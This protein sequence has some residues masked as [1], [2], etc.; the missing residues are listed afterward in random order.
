[1]V[2][3]EAAVEPV[4]GTHAQPAVDCAEQHVA[5]DERSV[6]RQP[7][8]DL[9]RAGAR[10]EGDRSS[11]ELLP[12]A[13]HIGHPPGRIAELGSGGLR[14]PQPRPGVATDH[15]LGAPHV[16]MAR[17]QDVRGSDP[18][19]VA[20]EGAP[21]AL[22]LVR[23]VGKQRVDQQDRVAG[24]AVD[25]ADVSLPAVRPTARRLPLRMWRAPAPQTGRDL[26]H[27]HANE[28]ITRG[29]AR[30]ELPRGTVT[31]LFTDVEG[32][33][34][35][36][37]R[38]GPSDYARALDRHRGVLREAFAQAGGVEVDTQGDA[39][40]VAFAT[41]A[42]A[43]AAAAAV[44]TAL[45]SGPL[46]VRIGIHT[47]TPDLADDGYVGEDVHRGARIAA[48]AHGGQTL[49]SQA[50]AALLDGVDLLDLGLHRLKDFE[51]ST[52]IFQ[53]AR[54]TF[55]PLRTPGS[56]DLPTPATPFLGRQQ[57]LLD[58]ISVVLERD[59][60]LLT[61]VGPGG[62]GKTRFAIE[63][64]RL[65]ADEADGGTLFLPLAPLRDAGLV[66]PAL[67][68]R[69]GAPSP[70][71]Q[72]IAARIADRRVHV[73]LDNLEQLLPDVAGAVA[74]LE[75][76]A[77][78][79]RV[80]ATSRE[81]LRI[82]GEHELDLPPMVEDDAVELFL[83]RARSVGSRLNRT[84][85]VDELC[86]RLDRLPLALELAAARTK[87]LAPEQILARLGQRLDLLKGGRDADERHATLRATIAWSHDLLSPE[88]QRAFAS[89]SV[90]RGGWTLEA[91]EEVGDTD[92]DTLASLLDKSLV[93]R[94]AEANGS[95]RYWMLETIREFGRE[96]LGDD[97][98]REQVVR[99]R[100]AER[101]LAI[102]HSANL[103]TEA[104]GLLPDHQLVLAE[105]EEIRAALDWATHEDAIL[106][107]ELLTA[108]EQHWV[109]HALRE[110][111]S[112]VES[113]LGAPVELP[114]ALRGRLLR[115]YGSILVLSGE[116]AH[117]EAALREAIEHFRSIGYER[118]LVELETRFVVHAART[119]EPDETR[120]R[121]TELRAANESAQAPMVE[122]QLLS[123][124]A[125]AALREGDPSAARDL[126]RRSIEAAEACNF[127]LWEMWQLS[128]KSELELELELFDEA[129]RS[130]RRALRLARRLDDRRITLWNLIDLARAAFA[131]SELERA[132]ILWGAVR[133]EEASDPVLA[134][135]PDFAAVAPQLQGCS[136][137]RFTAAV[138]EGRALSL[139]QAAAL[140]LDETVAQTLP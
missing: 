5:G 58:A 20:I 41:A 88:E 63:L 85:T 26:R 4:V 22:P 138:E 122:P 78:S 60:R 114:P 104:G 72:G 55:P 115:L 7:V 18:L 139:A 46:R 33:T 21:E 107:A 75:A 61:V 120:R 57:E 47:G 9:A 106:A 129:E 66:L 81:P 56:V 32:S 131:C 62:T 51:G 124:L 127:V 35:L 31:F 126:Y 52:R 6:R 43:A 16:P 65:L 109:T 3:G 1:M 30:V 103:A 40:F 108:L 2:A 105:R 17:Q 99:R 24:L 117:G 48:L 36:L 13:K 84:R 136:E 86:A 64:A 79:L 12:R 44:H 38:L 128:H 34:R 94:R 87:L 123:A 73:V 118:G 80:V 37:H 111:R 68:E 102:S 125:G 39:F 121:V 83:A 130:A 135:D 74:A 95:D 54:G 77:P 28:P 113:V 110:G 76:A 19:D 90:F 89:L 93:R 59:P 23:L 132:G 137:P 14:D 112:R 42:G 11:G 10:V 101:V 133:E 50:T 53:L 100:H 96:R 92:V 82:A 116:L 91:A 27:L 8:E 15:V 67:A 98:D 25:A 97:P 29:V 140:A 71:V 70:D 134:L 45:E 69:L 119:A 49:A